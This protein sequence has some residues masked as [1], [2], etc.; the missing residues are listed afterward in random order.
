MARE[1]KRRGTKRLGCISVI[2]AVYGFHLD[3]GYIEPSVKKEGDSWEKIAT[4][5]YFFVLFFVFCFFFPDRVLLCSPGC[6]GTHSVDQ[7]SLE[8]RNSPASASQGL[9]LKACTTIPS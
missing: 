7:A 8:L 6:P 2:N 1:K 9:G 4:V 5:K 3:S